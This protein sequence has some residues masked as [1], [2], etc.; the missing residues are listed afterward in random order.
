MSSG[1]TAE[2]F[3]PDTKCQRLNTA[4]QL[5]SSTK[6]NGAGTQQAANGHDA[7]PWPVLAAEAYHG[8]AGEVVN[9]IAPQTEADPVALLLQF[10][11]FV[12]NA[13]GRGPHYQ[14]NRDR[15]YTNLF[16][17]LVGASAK[18]RKG[19]SAGHIRDVAGGGGS[20]LGE[21]LH[22]RRHEFGRRHPARHSR[23]GLHREEGRQRR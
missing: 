22:P 14:V 2:E 5:G 23:P 3:E 13:I 17:L 12:G 20:R 9:T 16:V 7:D 10:L 1:F 6:A 11:V 19:L 8:L 4:G 21:Q 18:A 15:H